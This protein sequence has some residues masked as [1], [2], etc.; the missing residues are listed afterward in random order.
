MLN[1]NPSA[2]EAYFSQGP[3]LLALNLQTLALREV[4]RIPPGYIAEGCSATANGK[5]LVIGL[6]Q[7]LSAK[8]VVDM[9]NG[10][11][12]FRRIGRPARIPSST[13]SIWTAAR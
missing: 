13:S 7:D 3:A 1:K 2:E 4:F 8:L 11:V 6:Y 5:A 10:Y 9:D 12:G